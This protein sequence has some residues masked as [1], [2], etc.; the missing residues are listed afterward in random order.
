MFS[1]DGGLNSGWVSGGN[2]AKL[3]WVV[4]REMSMPGYRS[5]GGGYIFEGSSVC[6]QL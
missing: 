4:E 3:V 1:Y 2:I 5:C 6:V